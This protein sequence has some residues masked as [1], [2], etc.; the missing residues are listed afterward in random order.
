MEDKPIPT[1]TKLLWN[2]QRTVEEVETL[3]ASFGDPFAMEI[4]L[5]PDLHHTLF[6][7]LHPDAGGEALQEVELAGGAEL[8]ARI[9]NVSGIE[10]LRAIREMVEARHLK[11]RIESPSPRIILHS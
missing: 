4:H 10:Q 8:L 9:E 2:G 3:L 11:V 1:T 6:T 7:T 5:P